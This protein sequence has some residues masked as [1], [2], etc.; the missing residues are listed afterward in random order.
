MRAGGGGGGGG[1]GWCRGVLAE[2]VLSCV[3]PP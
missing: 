3:L 1:A 2:H